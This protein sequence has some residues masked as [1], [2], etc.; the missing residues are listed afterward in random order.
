MS[1]RRGDHARRLS[2]HDRQELQRR[3]AAGETFA[4][5]AAAVGC[6]MTMYST[7][8]CVPTSQTAQTFGWLSRDGA[9]AS[10]RKRSRRA[11]SAARFAMMTL[12]ATLTASARID[13]GS[14]PGSQ[15]A[16]AIQCLICSI[17]CRYIG[18]PVGLKHSQQTLQGISRAY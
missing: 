13:G 10:R 16:T 17:S 11:E 18:A 7:S 12:T 9:R 2:E 15:S 1:R 4:S 5:A 8:S 6:S 3:V 14:C